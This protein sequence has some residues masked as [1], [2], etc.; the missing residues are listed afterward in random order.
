MAIVSISEAAR[1][2][3]KS[4]KTL[5]RHIENGKLSCVT[6][7]NGSKSVD[8]SE[9]HRVYRVIKI[10]SENVTNSQMSHVE[11]ENDKLLRQENYH[12]KELLRVQEENTQKLLDSK[13]ETI[14]S[15]NNAMRL[16]EDQRQKTSPTPLEETKKEESKGFFK[17]L[18]NRI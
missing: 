2:T 18:F 17:R 16:L 15:L 1:L 4:V 6:N 7:D 12:L 3:G 14:D 11:N 10:G 9:L 8:T 5:Y 13:Q